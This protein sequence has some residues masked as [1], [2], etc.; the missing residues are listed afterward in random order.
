MKQKKLV[1]FGADDFAQL[2]RFYFDADS[3]YSVCGFVVDPKYRKEESFNGLPLISSDELESRFPAA[4]YDMFIAIAYTHLNEV[5]EQKYHEFRN[6]GYTLAT[7]ISSKA[8]CWHEGNEFGDNVFIFEDNTIQP[9]VHIGAD[10]VLWSGNHIGHHASIGN[11][12]F[13][14]SHAVLSGHTVIGD[15]SFI[16]V[17]A[18]VNDHIIIAP[19]NVIGSGALITRDTEPDSIYKARWTDKYEKDVKD[20]RFFY[21]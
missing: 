3:E 10:T 17:N 13:I 1:I 20:S 14:A 12:V 21:S 15:N 16:G 18:T 6:K 5:R 7:Y 11:H 4:G 2:A 8:T 9:Y 19:R